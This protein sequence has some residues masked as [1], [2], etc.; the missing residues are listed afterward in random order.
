MIPAPE[1]KPNGQN[2][3]S[4]YRLH[5]EGTRTLNLRI[6]SPMFATVSPC[7]VRVYGGKIGTS[8]TK[9]EPR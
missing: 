6:D 2:P 4:G 1:K 5:R 3:V 9:V 7:K 8:G